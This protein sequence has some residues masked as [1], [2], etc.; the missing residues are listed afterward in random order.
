M[1]PSLPFSHFGA[2]AKKHR[3]T[4]AS[5]EANLESDLILLIHNSVAVNYHSA[6]SSCFVAPNRVGIR[7]PGSH[8]FDVKM[9]NSEMSQYYPACFS[10]Y[11]SPYRVSVPM[12]FK[13]WQ[14]EYFY[15][16]CGDEHK[17]TEGGGLFS[18]SF[19]P[20]RSLSQ[21]WQSLLRSHD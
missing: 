21:R 11:S 19:L 16:Q 14:H 17:V 15:R 20:A 9:V 2:S 8:Y 1:S 13:R 3:H 18:P 7:G 4:R 6:N 12:C 5:R 10:F